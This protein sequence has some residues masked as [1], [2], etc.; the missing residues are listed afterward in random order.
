MGEVSRNFNGRDFLGAFALR[1]VRVP[2]VA[3]FRGHMSETHSRRGIRDP[4]QVLAGGALNLPP[5][6][7]R[8]TLQRLIAM[9]AIEFEFVRVHSLLTI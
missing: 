4:D 6:K 1:H 5:G 3:G 8:F 2:S 9:G 7:L